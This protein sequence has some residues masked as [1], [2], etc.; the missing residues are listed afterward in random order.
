MV[1]SFPESFRCHAEMIQEK[2]IRCHC[3]ISPAARRIRMPPERGGRRNGHTCPPEMM[4]FISDPC[5]PQGKTVFSG[6]HPAACI[7]VMLACAADYRE[8]ASHAT[9]TSVPV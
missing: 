7:V 9:E 3:R 6:I 1:V 5:S 2:V 8:I 4:V